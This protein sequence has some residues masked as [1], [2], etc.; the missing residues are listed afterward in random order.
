MPGL[1]GQG[2]EQEQRRL[3]KRSLIHA[4]YIYQRP[5]YVV[6]RFIPRYATTLLR[7]LLMLTNTEVA[8]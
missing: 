8:R 3:L 4:A 2:S 5:A 1:V 7:A 6:D